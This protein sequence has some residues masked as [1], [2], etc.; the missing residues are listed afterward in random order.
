DALHDMMDFDVVRRFMASDVVEIVPLAYMRGRTLNDACIILDEA[1]NTT[2]TQMQMF[3]T[4]M[5]Q[6]S[7]AIVTG[8]PT[9]IDLPE[10]MQSGLLDAA[11]RLRKVKGVSMCPLERADVV[12]HDLVQRVIE[13]Y[14]GRPTETL[15]Q[16]M[17]SDDA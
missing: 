10:G 3:L 5:G 9:Q 13:A 15:S 2:P 16:E 4:R 17:G 6:R 14:E 8:D 11:K 7:K 12:R 1:Q